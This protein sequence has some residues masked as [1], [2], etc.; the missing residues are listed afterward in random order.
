MDGRGPFNR[1]CEG[2]L[3][4]SGLESLAPNMAIFPGP[5]GGG[6]RKAGN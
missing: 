1:G 2:P 4:I 6:A 3:K 5:F